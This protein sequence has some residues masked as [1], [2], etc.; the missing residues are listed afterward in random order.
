MTIE[1][2]RIIDAIADDIVEGVASLIISDHLEWDKT[3]P[4]H[5]LLLQEKIN[6]YITFFESG[7]I[8]ENRT[9]LKNRRIVVKVVGLYPLSLD[10][11]EFLRRAREVLSGIGLGLVFELNEHALDGKN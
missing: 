9:Q 5:L 6:T 11:E 3:Q 1:Q 4:N 8:F 2:T 10:A 7:E